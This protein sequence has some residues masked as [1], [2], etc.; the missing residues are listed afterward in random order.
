MIRY[1]SNR[2]K[3][4]ISYNS[5]KEDLIINF[6][7]RHESEILDIMNGIVTID[8]HNRE[9]INYF[10]HSFKASKKDIQFIDSK[11]K[12]LRLKFRY[13]HEWS[14]FRKEIIKIIRR[15]HPKQWE[16]VIPER[17]VLWASRRLEYFSK[18]ESCC[19]NY[20]VSKVGNTC[21]E[22]RYRR[23]Q[24]R[25]CCGFFDEIEICPH[26]GKAYRL[27]FNYGH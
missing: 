21:Q 9:L 19:D 7:Y 26:D 3:R 8:R 25:G 6:Y 16:E 18:D 13:H 4:S 20:R 12:E 14:D 5:Y 2:V 27:G 24:K 11:L 22:R 15:T 23:Q 10:D 17:I 1:F